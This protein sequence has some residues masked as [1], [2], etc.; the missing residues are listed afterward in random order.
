[1]SSSKIRS[2]GS[3]A[4]T[5]DVVADAL[6]REKFEITFLSAKAVYDPAALSPRKYFLYV[7]PNAT[8]YPASG[9]DALAQYLQGKGNLMVL[10]A[11][12][13]TNQPLAS[14]PLIE[15][16]S[17]GYKMYPLKD[18]ASLKVAS[19]QGILS[20]AR[21]KLPIPV[22]ASSSYARP[23]G[24]GFEGGYKW[25]WIPLVRALDKDGVERGTVAWM[26]LQQAPLAEGPAFADAVRRLVGI[27]TASQPLGVEGSVYAVCAI[28][29]PAALREVA[30]T[31]MLRRHGAAD[32]RWAVSLTRRI[33]AVLLL[34][35]RESPTRRDGGQSRNAAGNRR[36][37]R[38]RP[39]GRRQ[40]GGVS[41]RVEVDD[42]TR[43]IG[44]GGVRVGA[45]GLRQPELRGDDGVVARWKTD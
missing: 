43:P 37:S 16:I 22:A 1:M 20:N 38:A 6:R 45:A 9:I 29:D 15:T 33:R 25:R 34:A 4:A 30:R 28:T 10:G 2:P 19:T 8:S 21:L 32:S 23:E 35:E 5:A 39:C 40:G 13:F 11:T 42:Q 26:L 36:R 14:Q 3:T 24:K 12:P 41:E 27:D 44:D 18:I 31:G 7:I 17:P